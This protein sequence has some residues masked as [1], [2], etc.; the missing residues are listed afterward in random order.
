MPILQP[1]YAPGAPSCAPFSMG[2]VLV[3]RE[4]GSDPMIFSVIVGD[5]GG[6]THH[7]VTLTQDDY[8]LLTEETVSPEECT[9]A[10][11]GFLLTHEPKE[12]ILKN[13][14]LLDIERYFPGFVAAFPARLSGLLEQD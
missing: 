9:K 14:D 7:R 1:R 2:M 10:A 5:A 4:P 3:K 13:F 11:F 8:L 6:Q 12:S